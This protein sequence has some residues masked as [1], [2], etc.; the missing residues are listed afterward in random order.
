LQ[1][2]N[3]R[4]PGNAHRGNGARA[5][6]LGPEHGAGPCVGGKDGV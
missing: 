6:S 5:P 3:R 2:Q 4:S 1:F